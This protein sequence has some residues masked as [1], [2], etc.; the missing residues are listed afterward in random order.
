MPHDYS[1]L[2]YK[3]KD[4]LIHNNLPEHFTQ[5]DVRD[6]AGIPLSHFAAR[7]GKLPCNFNEY[8]IVDSM[9]VTVAHI[10]AAKGELPIQAIQTLMLTRTGFTHNNPTTFA[11]YEVA[12]VTVLE[13]M[14]KNI[15]KY[16]ADLLK[17]WID[18]MTLMW[19]SMPSDMKKLVKDTFF[20]PHVIDSTLENNVPC[21]D[22][23]NEVHV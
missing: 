7:L 16:D 4:Q 1:D 18:V 20:Y 13:D 23:Q 6:R 10:L 8:A 12:D 5:W 2:F 11:L 14:D 21:G 22:L 3:S 9:G 15:Y 19:P 17:E